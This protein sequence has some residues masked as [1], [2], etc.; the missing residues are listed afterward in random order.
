MGYTIYKL[1]ENGK[2]NGKWKAEV[3]VSLPFSEKPVKKTK[4]GEKKKD[5]IKWAQD[6]EKRLLNAS[7]IT[8]N[9]LIEEYLKDY[10][11][12]IKEIT[13]LNKS[14]IIRN[15]I[16]PFFKDIPIEDITPLIIRKYQNEYLLLDNKYSKSTLNLIEAQLTASFNYAIKYYGLK[17]NPCK[18]VEKVGVSKRQRNIVFL[19]FE[20]FQKLIKN[21][22]DDMYF[23]IFNILFFTGIRKGELLAL[24]VGDIDFKKKTLNINKTF[25]RINKKDIITEPK[26]KSSIRKIKITDTLCTI[27][28]DYISHLYKP[29]NNTRLFTITSMALKNNLLIY[30]AKSKLPKMTLHDF[31]HSHASLLIHKKVNILAISKR[32]G[33]E[34]SVITL[35][36]YAHLYDDD[37]NDIIDTLEKL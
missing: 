28:K 25:H 31:R 36:T 8:Y 23:T 19:T 1:N 9:T 12:R 29:D 3:K 27:L 18:K 7:G 13:F 6:M 2:W 11:K 32:L 15:H 26:T 34:N 33:H 16:L 21:T 35:K 24:N 20:N 5:I 14:Q 22:D 17:E 30:L 4:T 10:K 37:D